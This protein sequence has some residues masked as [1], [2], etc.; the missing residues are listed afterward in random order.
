MR[1]MYPPKS[2]IQQHRD[3]AKSRGKEC[4]PQALPQGQ[5]PGKNSW[6]Y[7]VLSKMDLEPPGLMRDVALD[8]GCGDWSVAS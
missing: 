3:L 1:P 5:T 2:K 6:D 7:L 8:G 4:L